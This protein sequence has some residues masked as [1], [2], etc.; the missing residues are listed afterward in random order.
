M[1]C[2]AH[3]NNLNLCLHNFYFFELK[4]DDDVSSISLDKLKTKINCDL[5]LIKILMIFLRR[6]KN[7]EYWILFKELLEKNIDFILNTK[8]VVKRHPNSNK[9]Y[10]IRLRWLISLLDTF[11]DNGNAIESKNAFIVTMFQR[12][13]K[14]FST[15]TDNY[16]LIKKD[17]FCNYYKE[18]SGI[19]IHGT[20]DLV[21]LFF[22]RLSL[23]LSETPLILKICKEVLKR[24]SE[25]ENSFLF[26]MSNLCDEH[27]FKESFDK[28]IYF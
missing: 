24:I 23:I 5:L 18:L 19:D 26:R 11:V 13:E 15:L 10:G 2:L 20:G 22:E 3:G 25:D 21:Y 8:I 14:M 4:K 17:Y 16:S 7:E 12:N 6:Q 27:L 28:F 1:K 9:H